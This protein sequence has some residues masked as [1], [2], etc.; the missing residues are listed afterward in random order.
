MIE[1]QRGHRRPA[2]WS[3]T[4]E[5]RNDTDHG[6]GPL[7]PASRYNL[8]YRDVEELLTERASQVPPP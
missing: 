8:S 1:S 6:G 3:S 5:H 7:V 4:Q 2:W